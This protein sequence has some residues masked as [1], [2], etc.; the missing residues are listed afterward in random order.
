[1]KKRRQRVWGCGG[2]LLLA[3]AIVVGA[4]A[5]EL[6]LPEPN[7]G[8]EHQAQR[9]LAAR[10]TVCHSIDLI[11]QQR[12]D[13][14]HW[15]AIVKKM[16]GWGA[17]VS[18]SEQQMLVA[19]LV[20]RYHADAAPVSIE[21]PAQKLFPSI[22]KAHGNAKRGQN[23]YGQNCLPCH[24]SMGSGGVAPRLAGNRVLADAPRFSGTVLNGGGGMPPWGTT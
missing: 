7:D 8:M 3:L 15:S 22:D 21:E 11:A 10:C 6:D 2:P 12:L 4:Q 5:A 13:R 20:S 19:Y 17:Q 18:E 23:L 1:M 24:G 9:L 16:S 14:N